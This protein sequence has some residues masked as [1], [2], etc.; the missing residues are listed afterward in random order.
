MTVPSDLGTPQAGVALPPPVELD[1]PV[2][3]KVAATVA[4]AAVGTSVL[5]NPGTTPQI[6]TGHL[7]LRASNGVV[8]ATRRLSDGS[9]LDLSL[10]LVRPDTGEVLPLVVYVPGGAFLMAPKDSAVELRHFV[11]ESGFAV[12]SIE[13][14]TCLHDATYTEGV[15]DVR[16]AVRYLRAHAEQ[17]GIDPARVGVWGE[18]AGG[19]LAALTGTTNGN[20]RFSGHDLEQVSGD[21]QAVVD[22]F[23]G[24]DLARVAADFD[25]ETRDFFAGPENSIAWYVFGRGTGKTFAEHP[26]Q[27][28]QANP[29]THISP[30]TPPFLLFHGTDDHL[31]SPSQTH[32][33]HEALCAADVESTRY[34]LDGARHGDLGF[35]GDLES[36]LPWTT[37][38][39]MGLIV[40]FLGKHLRG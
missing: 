21:V 1:G 23:G 7:S 20:V 19:Y 2:P 15:E 11:A 17:Y 33:L 36:G 30:L 25:A 4:P 24:G 5:L 6:S 34:V 18:S 39:V 3:F 16:A 37:Q 31:V 10:D 9:T 22:K 12:A 27:A 40:D 28:R 26:E 29:A 32:E 13:Y 8:Y 14:R 38:Q 35:L